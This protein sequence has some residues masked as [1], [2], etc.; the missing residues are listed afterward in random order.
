MAKKISELLAKK[1]AVPPERACPV[2]GL[3]G[4]E[5]PHPAGNALECQNKGHDP[6]K[7]GYYFKGRFVGPIGRSDTVR[8]KP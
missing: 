3:E 7:V 8:W 2:C 5:Y 1:P 6:D 4:K